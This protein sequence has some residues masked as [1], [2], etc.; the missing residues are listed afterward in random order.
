MLSLATDITNPAIGTL[1]DVGGDTGI[2][3]FQKLIPSV[4]GMLFVVGVIL[5]IFMLII[6]GLQWITSGGDKAA[7][8]SARSKIG[9]ALVG[10][11]VLFSV[12]A[13]VKLIELFFGVNILT[14][15]I[16]PLIIK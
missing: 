13:F 12:F 15:D 8:E 11:V 14:I 2:G 1:N 7:V 4:I 9:S 6:G 16:G 10:V 5:F 3:F